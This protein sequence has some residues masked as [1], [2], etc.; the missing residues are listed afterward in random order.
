MNDASPLLHALSERGYRITAARRELARTLAA[1]RSPLTIQELANRTASDEASAYR[2]VRTLADEDLLE[3]IVVRGERPRYALRTHHHHHVVCTGC[4]F[5][6][7]VP[8]G[9]EPTPPRTVRGFT[10]ITDHDVT[11]YGQCAKCA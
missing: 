3:E 1:A 9:T 4:G 10:A 2:F 7:H 5:I 11:F 6:A 8:C